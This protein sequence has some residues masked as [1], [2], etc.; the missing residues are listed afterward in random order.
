MLILVL[1]LYA[2]NPSMVTAKSIEDYFKTIVGNPKEYFQISYEPVTFSTNTI[3]GSKIFYATIQGKATTNK[4]LPLSVSEARIVS[5]VVAIHKVTGTQQTLSSSYTVNIKPF[6]KKKGQSFVINKKIPLQFPK[7]SKSGEY[8][9]VGKLL[10][11]ELKLR[12]IGW[13]NVTTYLPQSQELGS[14][15]YTVNK[16][17]KSK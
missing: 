8:I 4:N 1:F 6:P 9:V 15:I 16:A 3:S 12:L 17:Q 2:V 7:T 13:Q 5:R 11:A 10:K 14:V